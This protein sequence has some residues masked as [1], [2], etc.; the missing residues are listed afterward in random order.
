MLKPKL[1]VIS[2]KKSKFHIS[3]PWSRPYF[4]SKII[5]NFYRSLDFIKN[6]Q[7]TKLLNLNVNLFKF[8]QTTKLLNLN[9]KLKS[10]HPLPFTFVYCGLTVL[11]KWYERGDDK[12]YLIDNKIIYFNYQLITLPAVTATV[13][14]Y[15]S[16]AVKH[17][18][19]GSMVKQ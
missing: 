13:P 4:H 10:F 14:H 18:I 2:N 11:D 19:T 9:K 6:S 16:S 3:R 5:K 17:S 1:E 15:S 12:Y 8:V 7:T